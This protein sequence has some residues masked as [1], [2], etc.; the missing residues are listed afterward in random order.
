M[1][2]TPKDWEKIKC[3]NLQ[4]NWGDPYRVHKE[5]IFKLDAMREFCKKPII[6]HCA[7]KTT[8]HSK[9]GY[10]PLGMAVDWHIEGMSLLDQFILASR[11]FTGIGVYPFWNNPGIH[12]D[13]RPITKITD[14]EARWWRTKSGQYLPLSEKAFKQ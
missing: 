10:H 12:G 9:Q 7:F 6:I 11:F 4:E 3:F 13:I 8:G 14:P 2:M 5:L 1:L